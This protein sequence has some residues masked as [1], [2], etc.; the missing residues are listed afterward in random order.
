T[1]IFANESR[2][3]GGAPTE[4]A[5]QPGVVTGA[6]TELERRQRALQQELSSIGRRRE[7][8]PVIAPAAPP[9]GGRIVDEAVGGGVGPTTSAAPARTAAYAVPSGAPANTAPSG[10]AAGPGATPEAQP[11]DA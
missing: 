8:E 9:V 2:V 5:P 3:P 7:T 6:L 1:D 10:A 4:G 11:S